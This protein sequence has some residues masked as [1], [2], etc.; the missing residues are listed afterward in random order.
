VTHD[1]PSDL[2]LVHQSDDSPDPDDWDEPDL[3]DTERRVLMAE[4]YAGNIPEANLLTLL[5]ERLDLE[6][7]R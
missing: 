2:R 6:G 5:G 7:L 1:A 3:D 4:A